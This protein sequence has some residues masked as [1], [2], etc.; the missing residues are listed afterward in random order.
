M[1]GE[2]GAKFTVEDFIRIDVSIPVILLTEPSA[3]P[4]APGPVPL[5]V[6]FADT[7]DRSTVEARVAAAAGKGCRPLPRA[8]LRPQACGAAFDSRAAQ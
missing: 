1:I 6:T 7:A 8:D 3:L 2:A 4:P 5:A